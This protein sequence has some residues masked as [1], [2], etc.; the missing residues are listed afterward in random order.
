MREEIWDPPEALRLGELQ[1]WNILIAQCGACDRL[2]EVKAW[3][4]QRRWGN[5]ARIADLARRLRCKHCGNRA[6][7]R[8]RLSKLDR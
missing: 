3:P 8:F 1:Q 6:Q 4:L 7:N 2:G 5:R